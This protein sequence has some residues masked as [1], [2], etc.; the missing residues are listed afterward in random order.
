MAKYHADVQ[1][2]VDALRGTAPVRRPLVR[3]Q[4]PPRRRRL[5]RQRRRRSGLAAAIGSAGSGAAPRTYFDATFC[6]GGAHPPPADLRQRECAERRPGAGARGPH[7]HGDRQLPAVRRL[8]RRGRD[9][10]DRTPSAAEIAL[11]E[12]GHTAFGLADEYESYA[13]CASGETGHDHYVGGEPVGAQ[14]HAATPTGTP[15]KW[16]AVLTSPADALPTTVNAN[17]AQCDPQADPQPGG[18]RRRVHGR[19]L[20]P[21][22]LLPPDLQL[23]DAHAGPAVLRGLPE[24]RSAIRWRPYLPA[25]YQGL[26]WNAPAGSESGWGINFAHQGDMIFATWFTYDAGGKAVVAVDDGR[27]RPRER[28][29]GHAVLETRG[30]PFNAMPFNPALVTTNAVGT[31]TLTFADADNASFAFT[32]NGMNQTK[33][34]TRQ[35]S[36][37]CRPAHSARRRDLARSPPTTRTCGGPRRRRPNP[38]GASTSRTRATRSSPPGSPTTSTAR[39]CGCRSPPARRRRASTPERST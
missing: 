30:P 27:R 16:R 5:D 22:R 1:G 4:R 21:L 36:A 9:V 29:H 37:R 32:V 34:I 19:A 35:V 17:C 12:M 3:H 26:W 25:A 14:R 31:G 38:A 18:L 6:S 15:I 11:H 7:D 39:R 10:F 20:L 33:A 24:D 2:F 28:L 8:R 23:P 13:G